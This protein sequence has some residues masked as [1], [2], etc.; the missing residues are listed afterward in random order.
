MVPKL[1]KL[2]VS[3]LT[4]YFAGKLKEIVV[5]CVVVL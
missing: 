4:L 1:G 5:S 2:P 3:K